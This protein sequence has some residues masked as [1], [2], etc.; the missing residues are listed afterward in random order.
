[1]KCREKEKEYKELCERKKKEENVRWEKKAAEI[2]RA[3][4]ICIVNRDRERR[5]RK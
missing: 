1:M 4:Y 5:E 3:A 2:K